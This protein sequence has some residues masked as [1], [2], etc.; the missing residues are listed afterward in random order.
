MTK[1]E[2][3][4]QLRQCWVVPGD[5]VLS[6]LSIRDCLSLEREQIFYEMS[7]IGDNHSHWVKRLKDFMDYM[8]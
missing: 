5:E 2:Y 4:T 8:S 3:E 6:D 7:N 1:F